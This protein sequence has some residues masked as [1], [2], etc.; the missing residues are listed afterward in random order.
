MGDFDD[1]G[2]QQGLE[3]GC[4]PV[5]VVRR[6]ENFTNAFLESLAEGRIEDIEMNSFPELGQLHEDAVGHRSQDA[7]P[8]V[9][10]RLKTS[11]V[12]NSPK[13]VNEAI[14]DAVAFLNVPRPDLGVLCSTRGAYAGKLR[15]LEAPGHRWIDGSRVTTAGLSIPGDC[16]TIQNF[17]FDSKARY[18][19]VVEK[20]AIFQ[21][22]VEDRFFDMLPAIVL[23]AK[24]MPDMA[25]RV[26]LHT[27]HMQLPKALVLGLVDWNP[28]GVAI[29]CQ[30]KH[31]S[32]RMA[33]ESPRYAVPSLKWL[34][35][36]EEMLQ[37]VPESAWQA[38]TARDESLIGTLK[39]GP[40]AGNES[41]A[42][43]LDGMAARGAKAEIEALFEVVGV[44]GFA[45]TLADSI[46]QHEYLD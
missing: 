31:G 11:N 19:L 45:S 15:V 35:T 9:T 38:L 18:I 21:R 14:Q 39:A 26:F 46:I 37:D 1:P 3:F 36:R 44:E 22:L 29:L 12:V 34:G 32:V 13:D 20:D 33:L 41:W 40:L 7:V 16:T 6:I 24:G 4:D 10:T 27:L 30:Y 42:T 17:Q 2:D 8:N 23:T 25:T 5:E 28:S 43:E